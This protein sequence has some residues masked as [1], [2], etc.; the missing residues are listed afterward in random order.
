MSIWKVVPF[1]NAQFTPKP[2]S[3]D[4]KLSGNCTPVPKKCMWRTLT[5]QKLSAP[6]EISFYMSNWSKTNFAT[7]ELAETINVWKT[8]AQSLQTL[9]CCTTSK[10]HTVYTCGSQPIFSQAPFVKPSAFFQLNLNICV[11]DFIL[12]PNKTCQSTCVN[13]LVRLSNQAVSLDLARSAKRLRT[14]GLCRSCRH[15]VIGV[16]RLPISWTISKDLAIF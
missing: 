9:Q 8:T 3:T 13:F 10:F 4:N 5:Q 2:A 7:T 6:S 14:I 11:T 15:A 12:Q 16:A 1:K